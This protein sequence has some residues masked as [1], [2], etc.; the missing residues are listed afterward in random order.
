MDEARASP[1]LLCQR[2]QL[3]KNKLVPQV[4]TI[5]YTDGYYRSFQRN[6]IIYI[7]YFHKPGIE[8]GPKL[9]L[10]HLYSNSINTFYLVGKGKGI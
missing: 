9:T 6:Q 3:I 7:R 10:C 8:L 1:V 4:Y 5:K 2:L